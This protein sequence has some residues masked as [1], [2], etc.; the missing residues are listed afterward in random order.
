MH[1]DLV[2]RYFGGRLFCVK[3][4]SPFNE[5]PIEENLD[6]AEAHNVLS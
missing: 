1:Y 5:N 3:S 6:L 2:K 4:L